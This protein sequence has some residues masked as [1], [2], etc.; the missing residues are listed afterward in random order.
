MKEAHKGM[1]I[2]ADQFSAMADDLKQALDKNGVKTAD[3]DAVLA[4]VAG[5]GKEIVEGDKEPVKK[6]SKPDDT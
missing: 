2:M 5:L 4:A 3:R 1:G 6:D